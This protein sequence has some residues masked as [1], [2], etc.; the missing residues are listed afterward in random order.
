MLRRVI[1]RQ[2]EPPFVLEAFALHDLAAQ[3]GEGSPNAMHVACAS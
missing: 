3:D 2:P 1:L